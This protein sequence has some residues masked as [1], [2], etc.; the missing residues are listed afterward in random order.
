VVAVAVEPVAVQ[1]ELVVLAEAVM[2]TEQASQ[3]LEL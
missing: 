3:V 1:M 2:E